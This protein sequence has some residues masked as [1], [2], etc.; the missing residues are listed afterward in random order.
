MVLGAVRISR[1]IRCVPSTTARTGAGDVRANDD[2]N[3]E[4]RVVVVSMRA[5]WSRRWEIAGKR[6]AD[7]DDMTMT[8]HHCVR[9]KKKL[10]DSGITEIS[11]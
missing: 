9:K 8:H 2:A 11:A 6:Y 1:S 7:E 4:M 3:E 5:A 10:G